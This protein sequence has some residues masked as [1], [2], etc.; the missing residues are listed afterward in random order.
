VAAYRL[1]GLE[2]R[3]FSFTWPVNG[4]IR[5][6][7]VKRLAFATRYGRSTVI[8][9]E[10]DVS[11]GPNALKDEIDRVFVRGGPAPGRRSLSEMKV[12]S[13]K[14]QA[15]I[16]LG[17]GKKPR[18]RTFDLTEKNCSLAHD[19]IGQALRQVLVA[20]G[21]DLTAGGIGGERAGP[22]AGLAAE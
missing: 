4:P 1:D 9:V 14:V 17:D 19:E 13:A 11:H 6:V 12:I 21:I 7:R 15:T 5:D 10:T 2:A 3:E 22:A 8:S 20:S 16:D 18:T